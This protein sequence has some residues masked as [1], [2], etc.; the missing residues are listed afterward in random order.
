MIA[1]TVRD[2]A[3]GSLL[4][5]QFADR[6]RRATK[7]KGPDLLKLLAF[8]KEGPFRKMIER[9]ARVHGR[10]MSPTG[11]SLGGGAD[12]IESG[13]VGHLEFYGLIFTRTRWPTRSGK[14]PSEVTRTRHSRN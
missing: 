8:E 7:L 14:S 1:G 13:C 11:D 3:T 2:Y 10:D 6:I 12:V 9:L 4:G 5:R